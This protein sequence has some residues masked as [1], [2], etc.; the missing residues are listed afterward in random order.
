MAQSKPVNIKF[1]LI[2]ETIFPKIP[3]LSEDNNIRPSLHYL[4]FV[5]IVEI[6]EEALRK[7]PDNEALREQ[8]KINSE[9]K[10]QLEGRYY[11]AI[12]QVAENLLNLFENEFATFHPQAI[13][14]IPTSKP[15]LQ[16]EV[17][18]KFHHEL[19]DLSN[20]FKKG[21][22]GEKVESKDGFLNLLRDKERILIIDDV[23]AT[24]LTVIDMINK[25]GS[26][27]YFVVV[28]PLLVQQKDEVIEQCIEDNLRRVANLGQ[29]QG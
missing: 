4:Q 20:C 9:V 6:I 16:K 10:Y 24:G 26:E 11:R 17:F 22:G 25:L 3:N 18:D 19:P 5:Q 15:H 13:V 2:Y 23:Y 29:N 21:R 12:P 1:S 27:K 14:R 8:Y 28:C 7:E